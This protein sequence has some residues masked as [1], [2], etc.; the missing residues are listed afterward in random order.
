MASKS[1]SSLSILPS[2]C[3]WLTRGYP[4]LM[5]A[6][7]GRHR[8]LL[9]PIPCCFHFAH[10]LYPWSTKLCQHWAD[11]PINR[12]PATYPGPTQFRKWA[13]FTPD[14]Y[15]RAKSSPHGWTWYWECRQRHIA[16]RH[17]SA[18]H[19]APIQSLLVH[20][21]TVRIC[22]WSRFEVS[23]GP[24]FWTKSAHMYHMI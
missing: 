6:F 8:Q 19:Q 23:F 3:W 12:P 10:F 20:F 5:M 21:Q 4:N 7:K 22:F 17:P 11:C 14:W 9:D 24:D 16:S 2:Q 15:R 1:W 13:H 18:K